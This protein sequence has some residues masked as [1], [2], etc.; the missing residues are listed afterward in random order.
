MVFCNLPEDY[1]WS[2]A[3]FYL[4]GVDEFGFLSYYRVSVQCVKTHTDRESFYLPN[5]F[6]NAAKSTAFCM[7]EIFS[8][9]T[10]PPSALYH[11]TIV[12]ILSAHPISLILQLSTMAPG[13]L[14]VYKRKAGLD[15]IPTLY[16]S[17]NFLPYRVW[18]L[19]RI[20]PEH[21]SHSWLLC[22]SSQI[23]PHQSL[24]GKNV[25]SIL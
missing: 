24:S 19:K 16:C 6:L 11:I 3:S 15:F 9:N 4:K 17:R 12:S 20:S 14:L 21:L 18:F 8:S 2:S 1:R 7:L 22:H 13:Q 23:N 5:I 25:S 10:G